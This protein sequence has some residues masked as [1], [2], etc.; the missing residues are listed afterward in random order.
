[1][2]NPPILNCINDFDGVVASTRCTKNGA[3]SFVNIIDQFRCQ[4]NDITRVEALITALEKGKKN[5]FLRGAI[6]AIW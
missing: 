4:L 3:S 6:T 1:M 5:I 2:V